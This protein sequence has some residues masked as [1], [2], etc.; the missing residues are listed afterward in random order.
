MSLHLAHLGLEAINLDDARGVVELASR[1]RPAVIVLDLMLPITDGFTAIA[2]LRRRPETAQIPIVM[3]S[4]NLDALAQAGM[5]G[6][7]RGTVVLLRKPFTLAEL[8]AAVRQA[9]GAASENVS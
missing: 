1:H 5:H 3:I 8:Q 9:M 7:G 6:G 2:T 4:G